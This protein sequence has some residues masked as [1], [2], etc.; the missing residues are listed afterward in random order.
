MKLITCKMKF[1]CV[2]VCV[3]A[4]RRIYGIVVFDVL[5]NH[6]ATLPKICQL[7]G[8]QPTSVSP[9]FSFVEWRKSAKFNTFYNTS[10]WIAS[11]E[12]QFI[13]KLKTC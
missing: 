9:E 11:F 1:V 4:T 10:F 7:L 13:V 5:Y 8:S 6:W 3:W 12:M 2:C